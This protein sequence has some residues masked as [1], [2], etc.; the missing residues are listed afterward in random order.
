MRNIIITIIL[1]LFSENVAANNKLHVEGATL[2]YNTDLAT[3]ETNAE[4]N[5]ED[6]E[7]IHEIL[8][9]D[10]NIKIIQLNSSGGLVEAS[11]YISDLVIDF[12]LDSIVSGEC[13][14]AC[15]DIFLAGNKR[16]LERGSWLGFHKGSWAS[17][18]IENYY[19]DNKVNEG[20]NNAFEFSSWLYEDT[21]K[22]ILKQMKYMIE[23]GVEASF[24]IE[25]LQADSEG[26]WYPRRKQLEAAGV[27][28]D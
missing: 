28:K 9:N 23:R 27:I 26:M 6:A 4:I 2:H 24:I 3:N 14:S 13:S 7:L 21:Q 15:V 10:P 17:D 16:V 18:N 5:W 1:I 19:E 22:E 20:W 12:E 11:Q 8:L 25:T